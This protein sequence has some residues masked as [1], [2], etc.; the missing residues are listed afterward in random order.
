MNWRNISSFGKTNYESF[1]GLEVY[2]ILYFVLYLCFVFC[3]K[4]FGP[5]PFKVKTNYQNLKQIVQESVC[6]WSSSIAIL[7]TPVSPSILET[8]CPPSTGALKSLYFLIEGISKHTTSNKAKGLLSL[9]VCLFVCLL[10]SPE[11]LTLMSCNFEA[12]IPL[13]CRWVLAKKLTDLTNR[14]TKK[15]LCFY[16]QSSLSPHSFHI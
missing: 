9:S 11:Q 8:T 14:K 5:F 3:I 1:L 4:F 16:P 12:W 6:M 10:S 2:Q 13:V 15:T 7:A